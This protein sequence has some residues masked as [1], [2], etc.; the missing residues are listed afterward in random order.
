[1]RD[2]AGLSRTTLIIVV[3]C[4]SLAGLLVVALAVK[5]L[6][7][8]TRRPAAPLPPMQPLAHHRITKFETLYDTP[9][10]R[11]NS[12]SP[13][14]IPSLYSPS[15][16]DGLGPPRLPIPAFPSSSS[17]H[18]SDSNLPSPS[19]ASSRSRRIHPPPRPLSTAS[20]ISNGN[21]ALSRSASRNTIRGVPH[22]PHGQVQ[23][24]LP[25]PLAPSLQRPL[26]LRGHII[27]PDRLSLVDKWI[28]VGR[29]DYN[30]SN[31]SV[32]SHV[33]GSLFEPSSLLF[34][35]SA[36]STPRA[37][38]RLSSTPSTSPSSYSY[39]QYHSPPPPVPRLPS[40]DHAPTPI[41]GTSPSPR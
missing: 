38:R 15:T 6:R 31:N 13:S 16:P 20:V 1:M 9:L 41:D 25:T 5:L 29:D 21:P 37:S 33:A 34:S 23:I 24:I 27:E 7:S 8:A 26:S 10:L 28:P 3:V 30:P 39:F 32:S 12:R 17:L 36:A 14:T 35:A 2:Q 22:S 18:S 4:A 11:N 40:L 19:R